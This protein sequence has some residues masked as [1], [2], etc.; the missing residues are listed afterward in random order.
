MKLFEK[1]WRVTLAAVAVIAA[2]GFVLEHFAGINP[3]SAVINSVLSP[4]KNGF[5]YIAQSI[6]NGVDFVWEMRAYKEDNA[7]LAKTNVELKR[8]NRDIVSYREENSRLE[9]LLELRNSMDTYDTVAARVISYSGNN[10]C[11]K[12]ELSKGSLS[13]IS[14][15]D[16]VITPDGVIGRI[17]EVGPSY[18]VVTTILDDSSAV[19]I[20]VSRTGG[21]GLVEGDRELAQKKQ[22]KLSFLD[23]NTTI[24]IGDLIETSGSGGIYPPELVVGSV[25]SVSADSSGGLNYAVI[26]PAVDID[27]IGEVLVIKGY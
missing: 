3:I 9:A 27:K 20:R 7:K 2:L 24:I 23:R 25:V 11:E 17:T 4:I 26:E 14:A 5:S 13:G 15:G 10:W 16:T 1:K 21:T 22:C 8:R 19:G 6:E 12:I 18:S